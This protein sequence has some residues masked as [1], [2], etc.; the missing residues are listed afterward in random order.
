MNATRVEMYGT[1]CYTRGNVIRF[2][3]GIHTINICICG[4]HVYFLIE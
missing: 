1:H 2:T 4:G 3:T